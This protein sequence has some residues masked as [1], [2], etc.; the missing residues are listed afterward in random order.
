[1]VRHLTA[2][3]AGT[4][5]LVAGHLWLILVA[6]VVPTML[7]CITSVILVLSVERSKRVEAIKALPPVMTALNQTAIGHLRAIECGRRTNVPENKRRLL[8]VTP[9]LTGTADNAEYALDH[10]RA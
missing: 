7:A 2:A 6:V 4:G 10:S 3:V 5:R 8:L 1:M 9:R